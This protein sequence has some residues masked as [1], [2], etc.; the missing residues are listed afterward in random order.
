V[1]SS[2]CLS[3]TG[4]FGYAKNLQR[5][6]WSL[7]HG[8]KLGNSLFALRWCVP[9]SLF[10]S[11]SL[12]L[13]LSVSL[14]LSRCLFVS[15]SLCV[16]LCPTVPLSFCLSASL[17]LALALA[18][19]NRIIDQYY[20]NVDII[21]VVVVSNGPFFLWEQKKKKSPLDTTCG[22]SIPQVQLSVDASNIQIE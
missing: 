8:R 21:F 4:V 11:F 13:C 7:P 18:L 19:S 2:V 3:R 12:S 5:S 22:L 15:L 20:V 10:L 9:S 17:A 16:P 1:H 6:R 14:S